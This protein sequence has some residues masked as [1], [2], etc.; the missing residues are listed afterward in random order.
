MAAVQSKTIGSTTQLE[1]ATGL[2]LSRHFVI[3]I[4][5]VSKNFYTLQ[6][7]DNITLKIPHG[8]VL[9]LL[10]PNGAGKTT[11]MKLI[12]GFMMPNEGHIK[13]TGR[14]W[15]LIG[16]KPERPI[17]P[18][19][20]TVV[21]YL[22]TVAG[23]SNVPTQDT[24][25]RIYESLAQVN[26]VNA[27][28]KKI[29]EL[30]K[31]MRQR[32]S[33]A[34]ALIGDPPL[35]LLDEPSS[36]LDPEGQE[37][38]RHAIQNLHQAGKTIVLSSHQLYEITQVCTQI[39][40]LNN[41]R[42]HYQNSMSEALA[43]RPYALIRANRELSSVRELVETLHPSIQ[44]QGDTIILQNEAIELRRHILTVLLNLGFDVVHVEQK[45]VTLAEIYAEAVR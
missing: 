8:A 18:N 4:N 14:G 21:Q 5:S 1:T 23:I 17:F 22:E 12:A 26:L 33:L 37:E 42:I 31:G 27:A 32:L 43:L 9:G 20:L 2:K 41:G 13:P 6:A 16:F 30:S 34:Q 7:L 44:I 15:P 39:V 45:R 40:V 36:G 38:I 29:Q 3:E 10:G 35:L 19:R 24:E 28:S 11:L 25:K